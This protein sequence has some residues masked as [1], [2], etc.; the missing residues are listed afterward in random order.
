MGEPL[1]TGLRVVGQKC[2]VA[3]HFDQ[4]G[5]RKYDEVRSPISL[6]THTHIHTHTKLTAKRNGVGF[7][8][9]SHSLSVGAGRLPIVIG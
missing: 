7:V 4:V 6:Y 1:G 2:I 3:F 9:G 8:F 5:V